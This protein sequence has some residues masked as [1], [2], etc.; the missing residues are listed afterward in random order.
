M[1]V[2]VC[3]GSAQA[4]GKQTPCQG[5]RGTAIRL[6]LSCNPHHQI[7][8]PAQFSSEANQSCSQCYNKT[9]AGLG[10]SLQQLGSIL[11]RDL[12]S[13]LYLFFIFLARGTHKLLSCI[14]RQGGGGQKTKGCSPLLPLNDKR[15]APGSHYLSK[16]MLFLQYNGKKRTLTERV[17][18]VIH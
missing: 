4:R 7:N 17:R 5:E 15:T 13:T 16:Q 10:N 6:S 12:D 2:C 14:A 9:T 1:Y 8:V 3:D 18:R 11:M